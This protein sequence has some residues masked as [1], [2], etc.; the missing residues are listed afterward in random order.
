MA[1]V[2]AAKLSPQEVSELAC[3]YASLILYDDGQDITPQKLTSLI[4]ASGVNVEAFWPKLF[5]KAVAGQDIK[6]FFNFAGSGEAPAVAQVAVKEE[7]K[8]KEVKKVEKKLVEEPV[9]EEDG[10]M[11]GLFD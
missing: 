4:S 2:E 8:K 10:G 7:P 6:S 5:A 11:G 3:T 9:E 1:S